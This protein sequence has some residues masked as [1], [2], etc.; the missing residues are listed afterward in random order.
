MS[1]EPALGKRKR[2][3]TRN[4]PAD[5]DPKPVFKKQRVDVTPPSTFQKSRATLKQIG[6][7]TIREEE[8]EEDPVKVDGPDKVPSPRPTSKAGAGSAVLRIGPPR[9][10]KKAAPPP[11]PTTPPPPRRSN[12]FDHLREEEEENTQ[13]AAG[14]VPRI[15]STPLTTKKKKRRLKPASDVRPTLTALVEKRRSATP[16]RD[17][18]RESRES[19]QEEPPE[20]DPPPRDQDDEPAELLREPTPPRT[21][22]QRTPPDS[23]I[24]DM[25]SIPT[26][27][28]AKKNSKT[29]G[30]VPRL[31][32]SHFK[33]Y[34]RV[35]DTT[36]VIDEFSPKKSFHTQ[37][38]VEPSL[39]DSQIYQ[40]ATKSS[41]QSSDAGPLDDPLDDPL[42]VDIVK[43]MQDVQDAY[44]DFDGR[45]NEVPHQEQPTTVSDVG[46][47]G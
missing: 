18:P 20:A 17:A 4:T 9:R 35:E 3:T 26:L 42:D 31:N 32:P 39:H 2:R 21:A 8:E 1:G 30:P 19:D 10:H 16:S 33:P 12:S 40:A 37:D 14:A 6:K 22:R 25:I 24:D 41:R 7:E 47:P 28:S 23:P 29:L 43:K 36:S 5:E 13:E 46:Q 15:G 45:A 44:F 27:P 11:S 38:T 34:L